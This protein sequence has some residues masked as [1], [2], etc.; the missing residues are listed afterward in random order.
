M[1]VIVSGG[2]G[3]IGSN[4]V[5]GLVERGDEVTVVDNFSTGRTEFL[6]KPLSSGR[7]KVETLDLL[8]GVP[9]IASVFHGAD[10]VVH[11]AANADVRFG[12]DHPRR[13][14]DQNVIA[15]HNVLEAVR[16]SGVPELVFSSTGSVYGEAEVIPTPED[17][18]FPRQ[19]S[20]Y[21]A[22][23]AAAEGFI[24]AYA[25][26]FGLNATVYRFVSILGSG[27]THGH[28][29]DFVAQLVDHPDRLHILG[30]GT[31]RKSYLEVGDCVAAIMSR[32]G[33]ADGFD[34]FNL[35]VDNYCT[36]NDSVGWICQRLGVEPERSYGGGDRGWVGD[37]PF[38]FL[39][40]A[41]IRAT[42]WKPRWSIREAVERTVDFLVEHPTVI[43]GLERS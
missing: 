33:L 26:G 40:T 11:L 12:L 6:D 34:V 24:A 42:G 23:K 39:D 43:E 10:S 37:N 16:A 20:L 4:L 31:Q 38:I 8:D 14:L 3:F 21:G 13:D 19:T 22:S 30:D 29:I 28:V 18:P 25:E 35:G 5:A 15:T 2:A 32:L 17:A 36:V 9:R 41:K 27:Y 7:L 1:R